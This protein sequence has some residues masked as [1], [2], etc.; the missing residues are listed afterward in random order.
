MLQELSSKQHIERGSPVPRDQLLLLGSLPWIALY[1]P[2]KKLDSV[3]LL[4]LSLTGAQTLS[5]L[6]AATSPEFLHS[7][8]PPLLL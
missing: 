7:P 6:N 4:H 5:I 8:I 3:S 1:N 2:A